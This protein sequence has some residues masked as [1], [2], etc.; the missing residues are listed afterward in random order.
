MALRWELRELSK[1]RGEGGAHPGNRN[2]NDLR[3]ARSFAFNVL[4]S[5]EKIR[6]L[7]SPKHT[8]LG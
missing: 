2:V 8:P 3:R 1:L 7:E 6:E 5:G 4:V